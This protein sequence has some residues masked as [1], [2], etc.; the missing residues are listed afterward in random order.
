MNPSGEKD[1]FC[2]WRPT[3]ELAGEGESC[4]GVRA[5]RGMVFFSRWRTMTR[6]RGSRVD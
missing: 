1:S 2:D 3:A 4:Y 6:E 5:P